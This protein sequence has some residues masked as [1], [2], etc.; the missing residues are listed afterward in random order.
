M[1]EP[2]AHP[3]ILMPMKKTI[4][5]PLLVLIS[6]LA[7]N[8]ANAQTLLYEVSG[9]N[10]KKCSYLYGTMHISDKRVYNFGDKVMP[11]F[12]KCKGYAMELI[13]DASASFKLMGMMMMKDNSLPQVF[14][15]EDYALLKQYFADTLG[16][17]LAMYNKFKPFFVMAVMAQGEFGDEME[18]ALDLYF[19]KKAKAAEKTLTGLESVEEQMSAVDAMS[20]EEQAEAVMKMI[21]EGEEGEEEGNDSELLI[22]YYSHGL[23][24]S[25]AALSSRMDMGE[26]FEEEFLTKRNIRMVDRLTP[27]IKK[28]STFIAVGA[29]HL[30][31][32][33][34]IISLLREKGYTVKPV[35]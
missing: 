15:A 1:G 12:E 21:R 34:G 26:E 29:L 30:P 23:L 8:H 32:E 24:D 14:G 25:L 18:E 16:Q 13:P 19:Y 27:L 10:V 11:S 3:F 7:A 17:N 20:I 35:L 4:Y 2:L 22:E 5:A 28:E 6:L 33:K 9:K 31:G